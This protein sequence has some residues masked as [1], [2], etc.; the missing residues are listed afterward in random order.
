MSAVHYLSCSLGLC[1]VS[2][3]LPELFLGSLLLLAAPIIRDASTAFS[4]VPLTNGAAPEVHAAL[5]VLLI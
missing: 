2:C 1:Y 4:A 3:S 5:A